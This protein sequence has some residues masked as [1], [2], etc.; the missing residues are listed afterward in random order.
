MDARSVLN[1]LK[2]WTQLYHKGLETDEGNIEE[3]NEES[4]K[5]KAQLQFRDV[6]LELEDIRL[7]ERYKKK[8]VLTG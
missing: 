5:K 2:S 4:T 7:S 3:V 8:I 6:V 1:V